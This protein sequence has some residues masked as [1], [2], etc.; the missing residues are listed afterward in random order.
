MN[1]NK[2][3]M[4]NLSIRT[5]R[6]FVAFLICVAVVSCDDSDGD[7]YVDNAVEGSESVGIKR[8]EFD[9]PI[10][11]KFNSI[12][13]IE[14]VTLEL[15][16][17]SDSQIYEVDVD[18][19]SRD[20]VI[21][22]ESTAEVLQT[23]PHQRYY[24]NFIKY[25]KADSDSRSYTDNGSFSI[26]VGAIISIED[27]NNITFDSSFSLLSDYFGSGSDDDPYIVVTMLCFEKQILQKLTTTQD[28]R[29]FENIHFVQT[30]DL[31]FS[32]EY[33]MFDGWTAAGKFNIYKS[34]VS[35]H[36]TY[37][38][39][40]HKLQQLFVNNNSSTGLFYSLG[41]GAVV[42]NLTVDNVDLK[43]GSYVGVIA[44]QSEGDVLIQN[45]DIHGSCSGYSAVGGMIGKGSATFKD[46]YSEMDIT[47]NGVVEN[48]T[49]NYVGGF[50]GEMT[51]DSTFQICSFNGYISS[52]GSQC[53]GGFVG[54]I[55]PSS[56]GAD[57]SFINCVA[58]GSISGSSSDSI[59]AGLVGYCGAGANLNI[60][61]V[62]IGAA[63]KV[64]AT[65]TSTETYFGDSPEVYS[66]LLTIS[67]VNNVGGYIGEV[68]EADKIILNGNDNYI[69]NLTTI[70]GEDSVGGFSGSV[71]GGSNNAT[72][73][74]MLD[75]FTNNSSMST[76]STYQSG[77]MVGLMKNLAFMG[78]GNSYIYTDLTAR[79]GNVALF[80]GESEGSTYTNV[81]VVNY[82]DDASFFNTIDT[83]PDSS[84]SFETV[85]K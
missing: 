30:R 24:I 10:L 39:H 76:S 32:T 2:M 41:D 35:F 5:L 67:G 57:V 66:N 47:L 80:V 69:S 42:K 68:K 55:E 45:V 84:C 16:G 29:P 25:T 18:L 48:L 81:K 17:E 74:M 65:D 3:I 77:A 22:M 71:D 83:T 11:D 73:I 1:Q 13:D 7:T 54:G 40:N 82:G 60:N 78:S 50:V 53:L 43:G 20:S 12:L 9:I 49:G 26:T 15:C 52:N 38:G 59:V 33:A 58:S 6:I 14:S 4:T 36:G 56:D 28:E 70:T 72:T 79:L 21:R 46:C 85:V 61:N 27:P 64:D 63:F 34:G 37:D 51:G 19:V 44:C 23:I 62:A 31:D 8:L 75:T